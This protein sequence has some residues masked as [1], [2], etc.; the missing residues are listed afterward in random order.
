MD[1]LNQWLTQD[2]IEEILQL[3]VNQGEVD[4]PKVWKLGILS[5][6]HMRKSGQYINRFSVFIHLAL[7]H[8]KKEV[9]YSVEA[10]AGMVACR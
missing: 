3:F 9:T 6:P 2:K 10:I 4:K 7:I 5:C 1:K 8:P